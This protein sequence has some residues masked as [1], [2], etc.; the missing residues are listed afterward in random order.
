MPCESLP[1]N[2]RPLQILARW[3]GVVVEK[4]LAVARP[5]SQD[6][7]NA[8]KLSLTLFY[9]CLLSKICPVPSRRQHVGIISKKFPVNGPRLTQFATRVC[10]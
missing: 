2:D 1:Q 7:S 9:P 8:Y 3:G 10:L 4:Y 6:V 5:F